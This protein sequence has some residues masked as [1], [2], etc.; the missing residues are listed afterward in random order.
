[1]A[2]LLKPWIVR[3][4]N[5]KGR[6][7]PK[8]TPGAKKVKK[9]AAKW[10][11]QFVNADDKRQRVPL[12]T[13]KVAAMKMLVDLERDAERKKVGVVDRFVE[14]C[15][16]PIEK[17]L[18]EYEAH[19]CSKG[20]SSKHFSETIRRLRSV[21]DHGGIRNLGDLH[22][23]AVENA[24]AVLTNNGASARTRNTY[25]SSTKAFTHW[26]QRSRRIGDDPLAWLQAAA[27]DSV[28]QRRSLSET[29]LARLFQAAQHRPLLEAMMIRTGKRRGQRCGKVRPEVK[30]RLERLGWERSLIYKT[31][32]L[33]G[34][35]RSELD[36]LEVHSMTLDGPRPRLTLPGRETKNGKVA[37]LP[38]RAD[39]AHDLKKWIQ[40]TG[41]SGTDKVFRVPV[42]LVK[43]LKRDL[44]MARIPYRDEYGRTFDVH[45]FRHT[46]STYLGR[47]KVTPRI[48]QEFM[49][50]SDIKLTMQTYT[51]PKLL[52]EAEALAALPNLPLP[53][54][55]RKVGPFET[56]N[57][58][59]DRVT[60]L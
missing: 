60:S 7:V 38:L 58:D 10:Y 16:A 35:R 24:L 12:C 52:D 27:V 57:P 19:L 53:W 2:S 22:P 26:C 37:D 11:G 54:N 39:L 44:K 41:K 13:D 1:M 9:R 8:G 36:A 33:T 21:L 43:I 46:T 15:K 45:A 34:L 29:E 17:H 3:Y 14:H 40:T 51:D 32:I 28:R 56:V 59:E 42:E 48:A 31:A 47:G 23:E 4:V 30:K 25:L 50:H 49:R 5:S 6:Q 20:V 55:N 18:R